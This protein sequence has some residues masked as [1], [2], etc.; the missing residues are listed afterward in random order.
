MRV[1]KSLM[2][3]VLAVVL[4]EVALIALLILVPFVVT[5]FESDTPGG[6]I[7]GTVVTIN[8][9]V[10]LVIAVVIFPAGAWWQWRRGRHTP[11][12]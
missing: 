7:G 6:D 9:A 12:H 10:L 8:G 3:G 2:V 5:A 1:L 11:V 4:A